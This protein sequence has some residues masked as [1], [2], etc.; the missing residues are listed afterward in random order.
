[1]Q[2]A[3]KLEVDVRRRQRDCVAAFGRQ[4]R[5]ERIFGDSR[6]RGVGGVRNRDGNDLVDRGRGVGLR[7]DQPQADIAPPAG[8]AER[9]FN[10]SADGLFADDI[11][12]C[13][14]ERRQGIGEI[15]DAFARSVIRGSVERLEAGEQRVGVDQKLRRRKAPAGAGEVVGEFERRDDVLPHRRKGDRPWLAGHR[16][17]KRAVLVGAVVPV[18]R[19]VRAGFR[20]LQI[21]RFPH[22]CD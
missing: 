22:R 18:V 16:I 2:V 3:G 8:P 4:R 14:I 20:P 6:R 1:M 21:D 10:I 12:I 13:R 17:I 15:V 11:G 19:D 5:R 9:C 7:M